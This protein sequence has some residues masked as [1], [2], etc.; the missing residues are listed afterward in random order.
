MTT[1]GAPDRTKLAKYGWT[2]REATIGAYISEV[3]A[4]RL[5]LADA[6]VAH[7]VAMIR[8]L[9]PE[10][11]FAALA[12][13]HDG[14]GDLTVQIRRLWSNNGVTLYERRGDDSPI[15][16]L[17]DDLVPAEDYLADAVENGYSFRD[18]PLLGGLYR[19][20]LVEVR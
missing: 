4:A 14:T 18:D 3:A 16:N 11:A 20:D 10:A 12:V 8:E 2:A 5:R 6:Q 17:G 1:Y 9:V 19:L 7:A 13:G 15:V